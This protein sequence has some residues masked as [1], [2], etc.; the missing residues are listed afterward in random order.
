MRSPVKTSDFS[1]DLPDELIAHR[2]LDQRDHSRLM[3]LNRSK[4]SITHRRF[5]DLPQFLNAGDR[6]IFNNTRV[7]PGRVYVLKD[8]GGKIELLFIKELS[9]TK[10]NVIAKPAKRLK[11]GTVVT[12]EKDPSVSFTVTES[13]EDGSR[14]LIC[15]EPITPILERVGEMPIPPYMERRADESDNT[16]Y[17]T[18]YAEKRGAVAAPTAG[19]HFTDEILEQIRAKGVDVSFV[20]LHVG[21]GTFRPVKVDN[22]LEHTMHSEEYE[23]DPTTAEAINETKA[24]GGRVIAVGTT[25]VRT[26]ESNCDDSG[27]VHAGRGSTEIFIYPGYRFKMID[28]LITN[29]H[30]S[31][32]TLLM[33]VSAFYN[34]ESVMDAY[35][36]AIEERYRFFSYGDSM[37]IE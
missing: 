21:I 20:T 10:W 5:F 15:A 19:L 18:V 9:P 34:R 26:L 17:Q 31:E 4:N 37:F 28:A 35:R 23:I 27:V 12:L 7:I 14:N 13:C 3:H 8:T 22:I 2:P 11:E 16:T 30:L 25:V 32:S 6:I 29:F 1:F 33:L 36:V 24:K